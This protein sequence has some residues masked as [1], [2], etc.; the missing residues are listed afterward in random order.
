M[1]NLIAFQF[2]SQEVRFVDGKPVANDVARV[3]GFKDPANAVSRMVKP[4]HKGLCKMQT[5]GG[6]QSVT[7]L[8]EPGIWTLALGSRL[9][10][11]EK[12]QDW[13]VEEVL[14]A[15]RKTGKYSPE[16][17]P[18]KAIA[19]Y[20]DRVMKLK[21]HLKFVPEDHWVVMQHCGHVLLEIERL[22]YAVG[23]YDLADGSI[24]T[25]WGRYRKTVGLTATPLAGKYKVNQAKF[26]VSPNAYHLDELKIF[27]KW[28]E[29]TYIL[30][31][32]PTYLQGRPKA[33]VKAD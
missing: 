28:L 9:P 11:A 3:L 8:E 26:P 14:P 33:I 29:K 16:S 10:S 22:G 27:V 19:H 2:E 30:E 17:E 32:L 25:H 31:H 7:V 5:P 23:A 21:E 6:M 20:S 15:I 13:L 1:T 18:K 4:K 24:G 12:F